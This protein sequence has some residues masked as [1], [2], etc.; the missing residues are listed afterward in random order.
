MRIRKE[1]NCEVLVIGAGSAGFTAAVAAARSGAD[2]ILAERECMAGGVLTVGGNNSIDEFNNPFLHDAKMIIGGIAWELVLKLNSLGYAYIPDMDAEC[3]GKSVKFGVKVNSL[4][5]ATVM[6]EMLVDSGVRVMYGATLA[7]IEMSDSRAE[8]AIFSVPE[9][10]LRISARVIIDATGDGTAAYLAGA[11][12]RMGDENGILQPA[13][14]RVYPSDF[15]DKLSDESRSLFLY[16][17]LQRGDNINHIVGYDPTDT[18]KQTKGE[19]DA[20]KLLLD[21][22][23]KLK[24][25]CSDFSFLATAPRCAVRESRRIV[26]DHT[27]TLDEY[28]SG[29]ADGAV[30]YSFWYVDIHNDK[31]GFFK[32]LNSG[33][34][35]K[36]PYASMPVRGIENMLVCGRCIDADRGASSALRVKASCMAIGEAA[37]TAATMAKDGNVH[38]VDV[39]LLRERLADNGAIVPD[40]TPPK[41]F[42]DMM[43]NA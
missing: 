11:E 29:S 17:S 7:D 27:L 4:A 22:Q 25:D 38:T 15:G 30:C 33:I 31:D 34:T 10:L 32:I 18:E 16:S 21:M 43:M 9:G 1:E 6:D 3:K 35:P 23:N 24:N 8:S 13:T 37:G 19:I 28:E 36:I 12:Y 14:M 42:S 2:V 26:C 20:R 5:A 41:R 40:L 39:F